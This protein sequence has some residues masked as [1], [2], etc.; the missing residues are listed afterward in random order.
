VLDNHTVEL[1]THGF[2]LLYRIAR[3]IKGETSL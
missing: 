3:R 1:G 2:V